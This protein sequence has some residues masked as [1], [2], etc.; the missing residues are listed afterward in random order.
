MAERVSADVAPGRAGSNAGQSS[1]VH[2]SVSHFGKRALDIVGATA[3][4]VLT[5]PFFLA[6]VIAVLVSSP[7]P[8]LYR[9]RVVGLRGREFDAFKLRTMVVNAD[10]LL[11][12]NPDLRLAFEKNFKL[13]RDPRVT[14]V[15]RVLRKW[16]LDELPQVFNVL[17]GEMSL[18]GPR[19]VTRPELA[20]YGAHAERLL[21]VRP[22][23]SGLW[24]VS[25][26]QE[27]DYTDR[28]R[29]DL[30]YIERWSF[31][32]DLAIA[33]RTPAAVLRGRGAR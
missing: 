22:G 13:E 25:G 16:S 1:A 6:S 20:K 21:T 17:R 4:L 18:I 28:V 12:A 8:L 14:P 23:L 9:R 29:L 19:M 5:A 27:I 32:R 7:G 10:A 24:Q 26:R 31:G 11:A 30:D 3:V 33:L 2:P 15:G